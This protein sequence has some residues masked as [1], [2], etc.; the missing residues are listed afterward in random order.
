[1]SYH[2]PI[3]D[4]HQAMLL[5][6]ALR[7]LSASAEFDA[8]PAKKAAIDALAT[9]ARRIAAADPSPVSFAAILPKNAPSGCYRLLPMSG[10][11]RFGAGYAVL[12]HETPRPLPELAAQLG[13]LVA[14]PVTRAE[15][16]RRLEEHGFRVVASEPAVH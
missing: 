9:R 12:D 15:P 16:I 7:R 5:L 2:L 11:Q 6:L 1:M 3:D 8:H 13:Q 4:A 14:H 10:D